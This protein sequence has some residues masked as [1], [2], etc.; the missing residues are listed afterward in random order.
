[1]RKLTSQ[2]TTVCGEQSRAARLTFPDQLCHWLILQSS[3]NYSDA[4]NQLPRPLSQG[5]TSSNTAALH[6]QPSSSG[7]EFLIC[8]IRSL[9]LASPTMC[10]SYT[11]GSLL[12][13]R[14]IHGQIILGIAVTAS[15]SWKKKSLAHSGLLKVLGSPVQK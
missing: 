11:D 5:T 4:G 12:M 15:P 14:E 1:M 10:T 13:P 9:N 6:K 7:L 2:K 8:I 3:S